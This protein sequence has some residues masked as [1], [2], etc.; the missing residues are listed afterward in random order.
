MC[1]ATRRS[2]PKH[3]H[4]TSEDR[5]RGGKHQVFGSPAAPVQF[6]H[7]FAITAQTVRQSP[8]PNTPVNHAASADL[9][10]RYSTICHSKVE[11]Q[12]QA[13]RSR[14]RFLPLIKRKK[15]RRP[16][17]LLSP[18]FPSPHLGLSALPGTY[19]L[20][21]PESA[22]L[23][24]SEGQKSKTQGEPSFLSSKRCRMNGKPHCRRLD[25]L[26]WFQRY[27]V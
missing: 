10:A 5:R 19:F 8:T 14:K 9:I 27:Q 17:F 4:P 25:A 12:R 18:A 21:I 13:E 3:L 24:R 2:Q 16:A 15:T 11:S 20:Y 1:N 22:H 7:A 6:T 26:T 23:S